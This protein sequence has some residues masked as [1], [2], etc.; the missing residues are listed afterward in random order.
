[1][2]EAMKPGSVIIDLAAENGGNC[3][4]TKKDEVTNVNEVIIDG[5]V[6]I[7]GSMPVH[8]S[9]MYAKNISAFVTYL[10]P[11]GEMNLN[12]EDEIIS[13]AMFSHNGEVTNEMTK[14]A[15]NS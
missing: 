6:N 3:S 14:Q 10:C 2:V 8:A 1:M 9:Q 13:G 15:L 11:E 12:L 4:M 5:T 7:A